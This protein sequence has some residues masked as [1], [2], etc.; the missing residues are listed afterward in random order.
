MYRKP[1]FDAVRTL[2]GRG[3]TPADVK[4]LD[5]A[6]DLAEAP[7]GPDAAKPPKSATLVSPV[8]A[9]GKSIAP[10][11]GS[12]SE[13]YECGERGPGTVSSGKNDAGGVSYGVYQ[14]SSATKTCAA[15]VKSEGKQW[16][17]ELAVGVAGSEPF[18]NAWR[19]IAKRE[20]DAFR[21][22]Q[23]AFIE[24]TH[25]R[26]VVAAVADRKGI[27]LDSRSEAVRN[28]V[29]SMAVQHGGA[30]NILIGAVDQVD[31]DTDRASPDYD[32]KLIETGYD[33][34]IAYVRAVADNPKLSKGVRQQ[35][36]SITKNRFPRERAKALAML[37]GPAPTAAASGVSSRPA[38]AGAATINGNAV[39]L[40]HGVGVKG[41]GVK[42]SRLHPKM[43][44]AIVAVS[45]VARELTLPSP[46][47][48]SGNDSTHGA[49]SLHYQS[50]ALDFRGN[51]IAVSVGERFRD[52]VAPRLGKDYDVL[53]EVFMNPSNNHLHVEYDPK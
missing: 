17:A 50:R 53:F 2:L 40:A 48:T 46:V 32:R 13:E 37:S 19:A 14:L 4:S 31:R 1:I 35:L 7:I 34:R 16:A 28:M 36:E 3:F 27:D 29:W 44:A 24:R 33:A 51:N 5:D 20:P 8:V 25:F 6:C 12:L 52:A 41:P 18:S 42:I 49:K 43:E 15:F 22:A 38:S 23:H 9:A 11:L 30:P 26:P 39:A 45:E 10:A 21:R 47:I